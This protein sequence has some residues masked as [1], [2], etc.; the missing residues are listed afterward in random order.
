MVCAFI[1]SK[2]RNIPGVGVVQGSFPRPEPHELAVQ[3]VA[4]MQMAQV[5]PEHKWCYQCGDVRP[6]S[7]FSPR[8]DTWDK[9]EP[10]CKG[11][12]AERKRV[13]YRISVGRPVRKYERKEAVS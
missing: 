3:W 5:A 8:K 6:M 4:P 10:R 9:L 13:A 1:F 2:S 7:Y 12:E 11:C